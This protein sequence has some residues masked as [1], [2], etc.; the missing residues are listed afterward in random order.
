MILKYLKR[1][2]HKFI[3]PKQPATES[4]KTVRIK[5]N[6]VIILVPVAHSIEPAVDDALRVLESL[7]YTVRRQYGFSAIDQGR[8]VM[9]QEALDA[10]YEHL[11]W[12]D[13]DVAFWPYD[14]EKVINSGLP[15]LSAPYSVKGWP[16]LTTEFFDKEIML[17]E[18]GGLYEIKYA[19]TGFMYTHRSV[20]EAVVRSE[21][22]KRVRI[23]GGKYEVYPYFLPLILDNEYIGEDF[24]FCHRVRQAGIKLFC[25][26]RIR[27]AHIG[28]YSYSFSF[29]RDGVT[30]NPASVS[31]IPQPTTT[32]SS[33]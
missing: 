19:A 15:F 24:A 31:Y 6:S 32:S 33:V 8:C 23:W 17:G 1:V 29:L 30:A 18:A 27:L 3:T 5:A 22:L 20:Y 21:N 7:G 28:K 16:S 11:F 9:A 2:L 12:I 14:V 10:G 13:A 4:I 25:D 26:T